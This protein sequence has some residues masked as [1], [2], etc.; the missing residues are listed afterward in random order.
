MP[1]DRGPHLKPPMLSCRGA[2]QAARLSRA[3]RN[4]LSPNTPCESWYGLP[5]QEQT[6]HLLVSIALLLFPDH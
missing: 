1:G 2:S 5:D 4:W 3:Y 6:E